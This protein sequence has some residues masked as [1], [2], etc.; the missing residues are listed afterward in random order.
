MVVVLATDFLFFLLIGVVAVYFLYAMHRP[1]MLRPWRTLARNK[2]ALI[3]LTVVAFYTV[4]AVVD[5]LHFRPLI[6][7]PE[8]GADAQ[9]EIYSNE[10]LSVLDWLLTPLRNQHE[11]T[12]SRPFALHAYV[13]ESIDGDMGQRDYPRL[14]YGG[15]HLA[16]LEQRQ[17]D[18]SHLAASAAI[19]AAAVSIALLLLFS[20]VCAIRRR[21]SV[22]VQLR[23]FFGGNDSMAPWRT[24]FFTL[25]VILLIIFIC[26]QLSSRYHI[27]GTD[28]VG[29]DVFYQAVKSIRTG[30][31]IGTLTTLVMLPFALLL[32]IT[33][34]Y[35]LGR[36]DDIIQY[37]YTTLN[38]IPGV[39]LIAA[40]VLMLHLYMNQHQDS[41]NNLVVRADT[42]LLLLCIILG[43]TSWT[44]LCRL[45][46]AETLK[47]K[48]M[49]YITA[50]RVLG[51]GKAGIIL[52]HIMPN[53][54]HIVFITVAL[55]FSGL[56]L[57]EAV[58]SYVNI[59]VDP[60]MY[61]WGNMINGA[62]L[63]MAREPIVWWS[64]CAA[65]GFMFVLVL[66]ANLLAD[67]V[68]DAFD[69]HTAT[70]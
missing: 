58:L 11:K 15:A 4:I 19:K 44:G 42:R 49:D 2:T 28:K 13:K 3:S 5:S 57:A 18:I 48:S 50:A 34:G 41:F 8:Q 17:A 47:V 36:V 45:L 33:A 46:R 6:T 51:V 22:V 66:C 27:L 21:T 35:F 62:R 38:S 65:F 10:I 16:S 32:G 26:V 53:V 70:R 55:D 61:S 39:L 24:L 67:A 37:V 56:V 30:V 59:G 52:R 23:Y 12:Y 40:A 43:V 20:C 7:V 9:E 25:A 14:Q 64:L 1:H 31:L 54:M 60:T 68:R 69:P 63:E 29:E